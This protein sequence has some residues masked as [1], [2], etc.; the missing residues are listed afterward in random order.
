[1]IAR[2]GALLVAA[3]A[4]AACKDERPR[5][6]PGGAPGESLVTGEPQDGRGAEPAGDSI[7]ASGVASNLASCMRTLEQCLGELVEAGCPAGPGATREMDRLRSSPATEHN[8]GSCR[9]SVQ[10]C[11]RTLM[12]CQRDGGHP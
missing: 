4:V 2:A 6:P 11:R 1:V 10:A 7:G 12:T 8:L 3:L 9:A 5:Q